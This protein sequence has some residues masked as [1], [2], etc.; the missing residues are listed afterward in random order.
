M[1]HHPPPPTW[2]TDTRRV[3]EALRGSAFRPRAVANALGVLAWSGP[4]LDG[5]WWQRKNLADGLLGAQIELLVRGG[6]VP[7]AS[8]HEAFDARAWRAGILEDNAEGTVSTGLVLPLECD[9][10]WTDRPE[11]AFQGQ[12]GVFMPDSTSLALRRALPSEPV[13]RHL[14]LGSGGGAVAVRA[15]RWAEET[16][17]LDVNPRGADAVY[18]TAALSGVRMSPV[19][20]DARELSAL[21]RFDRVSFVFPLLVPWD[22]LTTAP[23]HTIAESASLLVDV[24][25]AVVE[26]LAPGGLCLFYVQDFAGARSLPDAI[27]AAFRGRSWRGAFWWDYIGETQAGPLRSG[28]LAIRADAGAGW[29]DEQ[30][31][32]P[33]MGC[34]DWWPYLAPLLGE[35]G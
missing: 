1:D 31:E 29:R 3:G 16:L 28:L 9:L 34:D 35:E 11:R 30:N 20:G 33:D 32:A 24:L 15:A 14:D 4:A 2:M 13:A 23:L 10:V 26:Q 25:N 21:G 19:T 5:L 6:R 7:T 22:G 8:A 18:R 27:D 17:A 12:T